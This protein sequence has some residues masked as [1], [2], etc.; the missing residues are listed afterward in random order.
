MS[1][2]K[3]GT[4]NKKIVYLWISFILVAIF[5]SIFVIRGREPKEEGDIRRI[6]NIMLENKTLK[7]TSSDFMDDSKIPMGFTC[8]AGKGMP[9]PQFTIEGVPE[10]TV[11]FVMVMDDSDIPEKVKEMIGKPKYNHWVQYNIPGDSREIPSVGIQGMPGK[12][13]AGGL[14]YTGPCPPDDMEPYEH[15]YIF[16][17]YALPEML[18]FD[19]E[20]TLDELEAVASLKAID[21]A[22]YTGKYSRKK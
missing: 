1:F 22:T 14:G 18:S 8:D 2:N 5:A 6:Q 7:I 16:R 13:D 9:N 21:I 10:G 4:K 17:L 20:P 12:N 11:S 3:S 19:Q 15:R